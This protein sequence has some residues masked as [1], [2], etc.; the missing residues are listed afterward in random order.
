M[1]SAFDSV[2]HADSSKPLGGQGAGIGEYSELKDFFS[3]YGGVSFNNGIYRA[4]DEDS[5]SLWNG[6]VTTAFPSYS[7]QINCF[8]VDW[9]G[10]IFALDVRRK[11]LGLP[12]VVL[13][14]PGTG[15]SFEVPG[16]IVSFHNDVLLNRSEAALAESFFGKW[17]ANGGPAPKIDQCIGYKR[18]LFLGG[19]DE[20]SNL[21]VVGLEVYWGL[22]SQLIERVRDLPVGTS[23]GNVIL[24]ESD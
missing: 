20:V 22:S 23:I 15:D 11:E 1:F 21:E 7:G 9:L 14:E 5:V 24:K 18:P 2:F 12:G 4:F 3:R 16:N 6:Y 8:G 13:F 17:I 19:A 10:R